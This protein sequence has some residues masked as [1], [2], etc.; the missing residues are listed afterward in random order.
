MP[1]EPCTRSLE[2][3]TCLCSGPQRANPHPGSQSGPLLAPSTHVWVAVCR[4][5][6]LAFGLGGEGQSMEDSG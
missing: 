1:E 3:G 4:C 5:S 6:L 2:E